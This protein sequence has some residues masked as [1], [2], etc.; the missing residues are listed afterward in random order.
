MIYSLFPCILV[1]FILRLIML[2]LELRLVRCDVQLAGAHYLLPFLVCLD[3]TTSS[4]SNS[5]NLR[6]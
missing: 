4:T 5:D 3:S 1:V 2:V 6:W